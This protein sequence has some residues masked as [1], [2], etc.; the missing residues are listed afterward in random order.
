[1]H[2]NAFFSLRGLWSRPQHRPSLSRQPAELAT[3]QRAELATLVGATWLNTEYSGQSF[4]SSAPTSTVI[5]LKCSLCLKDLVSLRG[6]QLIL[7]FSLLTVILGKFSKRS[8]SRTPLLYG[9]KASQ[10]TLTVVD[11]LA[12]IFSSKMRKVLKPKVRIISS[13]ERFYA[14]CIQ[15]RLFGNTI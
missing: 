10:F 13:Q 1:M 15:H 2:W 8:D 5:L 9:G 12:K 14:S 4:G 11:V 7:V 6:W 3:L